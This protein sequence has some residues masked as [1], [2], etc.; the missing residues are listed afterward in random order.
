M[1]QI[2][3]SDNV[4]AVALGVLFICYLKERYSLEGVGRPTHLP[5]SL[6][7]RSVERGINIPD[8]HLLCQTL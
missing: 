2:N 8:W 4:D 5:Q 3:F 6:G 1:V 7:Y